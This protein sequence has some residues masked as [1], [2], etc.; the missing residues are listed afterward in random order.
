MYYHLGAHPGFMCPV[1]D[2]ENLE[3]CIL[4]FEK[5]E[6]FVSYEYDLKNLEFNF[7]HK[8]LKRQR[9]MYFLSQF[10]CSTRMLFFLS[11]PT[12]IVFLS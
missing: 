2:G 12:H 8:V 1:N 7:D 6:D 5:E 4:K 10:Q 3:N 11:T 9:A